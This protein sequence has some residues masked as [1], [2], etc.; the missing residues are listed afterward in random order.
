MSEVKPQKEVKN[1]VGPPTKY[2]ESYPFELLKFFDRPIY[3]TD[4]D[5][6]RMP[7]KLPTIERFCCD[8]GIV[9]STFY[10]WCKEKTELSSAF[11]KAKQYQKDQLMQMALMGIYREGFAKF[12]AVNVTDL[13]EKVEHSIDDESRNTIKLAYKLKSKE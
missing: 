7:S 6:N 2:K 9:T 8:I 10:K 3:T 1:P 13:K 4:A 11:E 5:G 12:I